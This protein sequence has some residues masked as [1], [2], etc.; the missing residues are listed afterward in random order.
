MEKQLKPRAK[1]F[2]NNSDHFLKSGATLNSKKH[3]A[4]YC[5]EFRPCKRMTCDGC[6][7]RRRK[8]F[9]GVGLIRAVHFGLDTHVVISWPLKDGECEWSVLNGSVYKLSQATNG[10]RGE[11]IRVAALGEKRTP[12]IHFL[13][14]HAVAMLIRNK[15]L[16]G[17]LRTPRISIDKAFDP[18]SLLGYF[19][20]RNYE[21]T[22]LLPDRPKRIRLLSG[23]RGMSYGYPGKNQWEAYKLALCGDCSAVLNSG[24]RGAE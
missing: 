20:D 4:T 11:Y 6:S 8:Y 3:K 5:S 21:H 2:E 9:I 18:E 23:S 13:V 17:S 7:D 24:T 12:H 10:K 22:Y 15:A 19:Y 14:T 1:Y 16:K